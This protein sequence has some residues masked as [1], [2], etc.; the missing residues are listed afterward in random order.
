MNP[1]NINNQSFYENLMDNVQ[2]EEISHHS[3]SYSDLLNIYV[4]S[5]KDNTKMKYRLKISFFIITIGIL[6]IIVAYSGFSLLYVSKKLNSFNNLNEL[7]IEAIFG[8]L[9]IILPVI[10]ALIVAFIEIPKIIAQ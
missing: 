1:P 4:N 8:I 6:I 10:S 2:K 9:T 3:Q 5:I 7:S